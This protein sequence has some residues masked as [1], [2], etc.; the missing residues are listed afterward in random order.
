MSGVARTVSLLASGVATGAVVLYVVFTV[1][2]SVSPAEVAGASAAVAALAA[3]L[4]MRSIRLE[5]EL[6][7]QG[8]D[9]QLRSSFNRQ[10]ERRG[11]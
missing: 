10:R 4:L 7:S 5:Y 2:A 1:V 6:R 3:L 8:G 11:F 9:P